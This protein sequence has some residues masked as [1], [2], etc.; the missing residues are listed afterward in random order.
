MAVA[1]AVGGGGCDAGRGGEGRASSAVQEEGTAKSE[2]DKEAVGERTNEEAPK[3]P[4]ADEAVFAGGEVTAGEIL[5]RIGGEARPV[6]FRPVGNTSIVFKV[7]LEG[8]MDA[9]FKPSWRRRP[10][11]YLAEVAAY[12]VARLLGLDNVPPAIT[13]RIGKEELRGGLLG[14]AASAWDDFERLL[15]WGDDRQ[16]LGAAVYWVKG[17]QELGLD[18]REGI[19]SWSSWLRVDGSSVE[20][21]KRTLAADLSNMLAFD[22]LIGNADRFSGGNMKGDEQGR[23]LFIRDHDLAF[24]RRLSDR[25]HER[26]IGRL[27]RAERFSRGFFGRVQGLGREEVEEE[28]GL[29]PASGQWKR[30]ILDERQL[31]G[32]FDRREALLSH[33]TSLIALHG[34]ERVLV[35]P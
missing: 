19:E 5:K 23:R 8:G 28:L 2:R 24:P 25:G 35:F 18:S 20:D 31:D 10:S 34:E 7:G 12:R 32:L 22:Y 17:M 30:T 15:L 26:L 21:E 3:E 11:G 4:S 13:R 27:L 1:M 16:V 33:I 29:D 14:E 9:A 6:G